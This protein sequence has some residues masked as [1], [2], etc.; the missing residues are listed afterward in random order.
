MATGIG[1]DGDMYTPR[2]L[3]L[4]REMDFSAPP[5]LSAHKTPPMNFG[6]AS[7]A[8]APSKPLPAG[9]SA[10]AQPPSNVEFTL[11]E[12]H[13]YGP[14]AEPRLA[15]VDHGAYPT[16]F[17]AP[18][19]GPVLKRRWPAHPEPPGEATKRPGLF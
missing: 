13:V 16:P 9:P 5:F 8:A 1:S 14:T 17:E 19:W 15:R 18:P 10:P 11:G 2:S 7:S 3:A 6:M 4:G 12:A